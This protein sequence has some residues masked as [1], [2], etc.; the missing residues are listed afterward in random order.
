MCLL[1]PWAS[2]RGHIEAKEVQDSIEAF[3]V[4]FR[5]LRP[6]ATL[7]RGVTLWNRFRIIT[8]PWASARGHIEAISC[9]LTF[10]RTVRFPWASARGHIEASRITYPPDPPSN[11]R[12][13][14]P[15]ATLKPKCPSRT[16]PLG[17][18]FRGLRPAATLKPHGVRSQNQGG[19]AFPWASARGHIE[20]SPRSMRLWGVG[21][22]P[23]ASARGHIEATES[24]PT[25]PRLSG[26]SVGFGPRPH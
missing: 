21:I 5:G 20:A 15:A 1:F 14:R 25:A 23:W 17:T 9:S 16:H 19:M 18:Y 24:W 10:R 12:G 13:L 7:K 8:F 22:F 26:I 2:A 4:N 6:A 11:F 3:S